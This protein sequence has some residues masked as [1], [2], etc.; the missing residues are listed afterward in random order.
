[1]T[2]T[3]S[4]VT[5]ESW[6][7]AATSRLYDQHL[8]P[9]GAGLLPPLKLSIGWPKG[10]S[11]KKVRLGECWYGES[12]ADT[13]THHIY[14]T[15]ALAEPVEVLRV[16][17]HELVHAA[18]GAAAKHRGK[19]AKLAGRVGFESPWTSTPASAGLVEALTTLAAK[20]GAYPHVVLHP[21]VVKKQTTRMI[22]WEC[23]HGVKI[24]RAGKLNARCLDCGEMF[25]RQDGG[26]EEEGED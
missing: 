21:R 25:V 1:M 24:R 22:L 7:E 8:A 17:L 13:R 14:I 20:L 10:G 2:E 4:H 6:L 12:C 23:A 15:P 9:A 11:G 19:F 16:L 5:R 3:T 26:D 18:V